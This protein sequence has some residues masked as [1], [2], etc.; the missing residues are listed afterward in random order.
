MP[1]VYSTAQWVLLCSRRGEG[2]VLSS[3][4]LQP[5]PV[6]C[7]SGAAVRC[8]AGHSPASRCAA[9]QLCGPEHSFLGSFLIHQ[10]CW[11]WGADEQIGECVAHTCP[12]SWDFFS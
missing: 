12:T 3:R 5:C 1:P 2:L 6:H 4:V 7:A 9:R 10:S 8:Y 11:R